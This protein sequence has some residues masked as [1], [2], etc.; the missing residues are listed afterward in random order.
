MNKA[1]YN[2]EKYAE[3]YAIKHNISVEEAK[4]HAMVR[5]AKN[6]YEKGDENDQEINYISC[7][8]ETRT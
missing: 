1:E 8:D 3:R 2:Y 5:N 4:T 6:F 7:E